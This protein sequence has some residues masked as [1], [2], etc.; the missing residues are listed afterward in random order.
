MTAQAHEKIMIDG[1]IE[2]MATCPELP[3]YSSQILEMHE[4]EIAGI[5]N[6]SA[7]CRQYVGTWKISDDKLYLIGVEGRYSLS[8]NQEIFSYWFSGLLRI[9]QG[10]ILKYVH[11]GYA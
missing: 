2:L 5:F 1:N 9:Q 6:S 3:V 11:G 4:D 7:C 8:E 10:D